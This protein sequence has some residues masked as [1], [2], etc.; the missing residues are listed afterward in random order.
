MIK[1][2]TPAVLFVFAFMAR[3]LLVGKGL[4]HPDAIRFMSSA[5]ELANSGQLHGYLTGYNLPVILGALFLRVGGLFGADAARSLNMLSVFCGAAA[6]PIF[7][8]LCCRLFDRVTALLGSFLLLSLPHLFVLSTFA[9][10]Q[11]VTLPFL[12]LGLCM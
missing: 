11:I 1:P 6:I 9:N 10:S 8:I 3:F 5:Q 7:Y 2:F 12:L 4:Y